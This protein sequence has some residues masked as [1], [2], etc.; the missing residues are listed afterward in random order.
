M[1]TRTGS[2][3]VK[4]VKLRDDDAELITTIWNDVAVK[5][6]TKIG[7]RVCIMNSVARYDT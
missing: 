2:Q 1:Q 6:P 4:E 3:T 7:K 5:S